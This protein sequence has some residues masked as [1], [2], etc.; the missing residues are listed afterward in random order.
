MVNR[1]HPYNVIAG[2][3]P[4]TIGKRFT[5][6]P[7]TR[8]L[9]MKFFRHIRALIRHGNNV[10][11]RRRLHSIQTINNFY[12]NVFRQNN[13]LYTTTIIVMNVTHRNRRPHPRVLPTIVILGTIRHPRGNLL[14]R[15]L[16]R[17][18]TTNGP[19]RGRTSIP[20][21][22]PM[23][24]FGIR[25]RRSNRSASSRTAKTLPDTCRIPS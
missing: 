15:L 18:F 8:G 20:R 21:M 16:Y 11:V 14:Y 2:S 1:P 25:E 22:R 4:S 12:F 3:H 24:N 9:L 17:H 23:S 5:R 10:L 13:I 7:R 6:R 19:L